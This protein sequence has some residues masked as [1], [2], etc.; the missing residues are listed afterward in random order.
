MTAAPLAGDP[1]AAALREEALRI[2]QTIIK[3][4]GRAPMLAV[5][6]SADESAK[7]YAEKI[8]KDA[9]KCEITVRIVPFAADITNARAVE[10]LDSLAAD[11]EIDAILL[12]T[13]L[14]ASVDAAALADRIPAGRDVDGASLASAG[15]AALGRRGARFPATAAAV[16]EI[17]RRS[18][19]KIAGSRAVVLGRSAVVGRPAAFGLLTMDATVTV[20]HSK[21]KDIINI[22]KEADIVV[23]AIGKPAF[24]DESW[25]KP[26]ALVV[27]VGIHR[28]TDAARVRELFIN[29]PAR[30]AA[31]E[32]K[33]SVVVGDCHPNVAGVAG[34]LTPVPG[35]VGPVTSAILLKNAALA[36]A[37]GVSL[38]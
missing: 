9:A 10:L 23:A 20:A 16:L 27:D 36:A 25:I 5:V 26:G 17:V 31:F 3:T 38:N 6:A 28:L 12:Q 11:P 22:T 34:M 21:T 2:A 15:S 30:V 19:I 35:G 4:R 7:M 32:Q 1:I 24:V 29:D 18:N 13:P 37:G 33:G 14:P 8:R